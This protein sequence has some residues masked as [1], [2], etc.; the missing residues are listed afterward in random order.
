MSSVADVGRSKNKARETVTAAAEAAAAAATWIQRSSEE[1][2]DELELEI[3]HRR[4]RPRKSGTEG[5]YQREVVRGA[6]AP[7]RMIREKT[8]ME[9][10]DAVV[11]RFGIP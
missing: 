11:E 9:L 4:I 7:R 10:V 3:S 8:Q 2:N 5:V 1:T 6:E